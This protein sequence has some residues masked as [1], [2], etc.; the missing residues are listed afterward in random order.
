[1][2]NKTIIIGL[3]LHGWEWNQ[4]LTHVHGRV[5]MFFKL[6]TLYVV[7][8]WHCIESVS[9]LFANLLASKRRRSDNSKFDSEI[10]KIW[11]KI[12]STTNKVQFLIGRI[13]NLLVDPLMWWKKFLLFNN[14]CK[15]KK[16]KN[17]FSSCVV[18]KEWYIWLKQND[19]SCSSVNCTIS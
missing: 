7:F 5:Y 12:I 6:I 9:Y 14:V 13:F 16:R 15:G 8:S 11:L 3:V 10:S 18:D 4:F 1:V 19:V 2:K 17:V